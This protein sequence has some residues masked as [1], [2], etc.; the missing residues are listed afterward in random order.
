MTP[1]AVHTAP[2]SIA[3]RSVPSKLHSAA[4]S[5][6]VPVSIPLFGTVADPAPESHSAVDGLGEGAAL[7]EAI[8][9]FVR[10][11]VVLS[12]AQRT[13][14]ATWIVHTHALLAAET[15][16]YLAITS[17]E[18]QSGKTRLLETLEIL[19]H[20]P[21]LTGRAT[22]AVLVR[23][24]EA[25]RPTLLLDESD[26]AFNGEQEY[27]ET[28]RGVLNTGHR[29]GGCASLCVGQGANLSFKDFETFCPK[30]IAGI[31]QLP[32]TVADRSIPIRLKRKAP[33]ETVERFRRRDISGHANDLRQ[34]ILAWASAHVKSLSGARPELPETLSDRQQDG[35]EPLLAIADRAGEEWS[36]R[37]R[38]AIVEILGGEASEDQSIRVRLLADIRDVFDSS[39][40]E[41]LSS[42]ELLSSL[43]EIETSPWAD[44]K[45]GKPL[46]AVGLAHLLRPFLICPRTI[47]VD[48]ATPKGYLRDSF[49][50]AWGRYLSQR[51]P[52]VTLD[53]DTTPQ[54]PPQFA[55]H[56]EN[57]K[58]FEPQPT[59]AV[60]WSE[61]GARPFRRAS[62]I[63]W[64][65]TN[66]RGMPTVFTKT[67]KSEELTPG[68]PCLRLLTG[69][70]HRVTG[71]R[72]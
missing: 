38:R 15:T 57:A 21:W 54:H 29:R 47:R 23:K 48:D 44:W 10:R 5:G 65:S 24:I 62:I 4:G 2:Q 50:D 8:H 41:K 37:L 1:V 71:F 30:A 22:A 55:I 61:I 40:A 63:S 60:A 59:I 7:L 53:P 51:E 64:T 27:A 12:D 49:L 56:A 39:R 9:H 35:V 25:Q 18:K 43:A 46:N 6:T 19:V 31:G 13:V 3:S 68:L 32:D 11:F 67:W 42:I 69:F 52:S 70:W 17:A 28:L 16:P 20:K 33:G 26:A 36:R 58:S 66:F 14:I 34:R 72:H 45:H